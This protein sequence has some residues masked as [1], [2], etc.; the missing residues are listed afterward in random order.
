MTGQT[1]MGKK[2]VGETRG[3]KPEILKNQDQWRLDKT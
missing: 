1:V 3:S 2:S